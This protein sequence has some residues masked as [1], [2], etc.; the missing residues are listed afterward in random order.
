MTP[1][2]AD[3]PAA[4]SRRATSYWTVAG[5]AAV[6][7][8]AAAI[9]IVR[10]GVLAVL[11]FPLRVLG[12]ILPGGDLYGDALWVAV[13]LGWAGWCLLAFL[14]APLLVI[15]VGWALKL[16]PALH[17]HGGIW[18]QVVRGQRGLPLAA[19]GWAGALAPTLIVGGGVVLGRLLPWPL[20]VA[21]LTSAALLSPAIL[22][23]AEHPMVALIR[24]CA[25]LIDVF[26]KRVGDSAR[27]ASLALV[28]VV[29]VAV[30]QR[31][32]FGITFTK[33]DEL[34]VYLHAAL[35]ML[36]AAATLKADGHVRVDVFYGGATP[37]QRALIN[38]L[39]VYVLLAPMCLVIIFGSSRYVDLAWR[40][41][42][43]STESDGLPLVFLLKTAI[44]TFAVLV[45]A[46]AAALAAREALVLVGVDQPEEHAPPHHETV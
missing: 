11:T 2:D 20:S 5:F 43:G 16:F 37:M 21:V 31:Y 36:M 9:P 42:E 30:T 32:V 25:T 24:L 23:S 1:S 40:V 46:Q 35:F 13:G 27:W 6:V 14:W 4:G 7:I 10:T 8:L 45:L 29:A 15:A 12:W 34:M 28:L 19:A 41:G 17:R 33:L 3:D 26:C 44:P 22:R 38:F 18:A 39:G